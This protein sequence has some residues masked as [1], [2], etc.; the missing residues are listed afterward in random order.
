M[1]K[2]GK[3]LNSQPRGGL[4]LGVMLIETTLMAGFLPAGSPRG[5]Q[6]TRR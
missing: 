1:R 4:R 2:V 3:A 5:K 6:K